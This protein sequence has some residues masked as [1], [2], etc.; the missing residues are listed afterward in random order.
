MGQR[1]EAFRGFGF[2]GVWLVQGSHQVPPGP[3]RQS[4]ASPRATGDCLPACPNDR[5]PRPRHSADPP[6]PAPAIPAHQLPVVRPRCLS[7]G[8]LPSL[9]RAQEKRGASGWLA[10]GWLSEVASPPPPSSPLPSQIA[11]G[12]AFHAG[13]AQRRLVR[14]SPGPRPAACSIVWPQRKTIIST[15]FTVSKH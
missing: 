2:Q 1:V 13:A 7:E 5:A 12:S 3:T 9:H 4:P 10:A 15:Q 11:P 14:T 6:P 8:R